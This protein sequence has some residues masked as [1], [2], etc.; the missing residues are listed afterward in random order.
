MAG[1]LRQDLRERMRSSGHLP[2]VDFMQAALYH[3]SDGH[4]ATRVPGHGSHYRT[5]PSLTPWFGRLVARELR[6][7]SCSARAPAP[8]RLPAFGWSRVPAP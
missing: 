2:F 5:S 4:Y 1:S 7:I 8:E 6:R 3:P